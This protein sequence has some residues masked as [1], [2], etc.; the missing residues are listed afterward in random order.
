MSASTTSP[1][2]VSFNGNDSTSLY[3]EAVAGLTVTMPG[4]I[5][6]IAIEGGA[7]T[8]QVFNTGA[9]LAHS[10]DRTSS[11]PANFIFDSD[12][13]ITSA[14]ASGLDNATAHIEV[15]KG[16]NAV[17]KGVAIATSGGNTYLY[18]ANFRSGRVEVYDTNYK[19]VALTRL[20]TDFTLPSGY[21]PFNIQELGG[22]LYVT[23]AK[24]DDQ[25]HDD[26]AG[27]G[28]GFIDVFNNDGT[29]VGRLFS[30]GA[31]DSPWGLAIAPAGFGRFGRALLGSNFG[32]GR[33][34]A[35]DPVTGDAPG[36]SAANTTGRS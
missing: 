34:N 23:Y 35:Y 36:P 25:L 2:W 5:T 1:Q 19:P 31:L 18:A 10:F 27:L 8:G 13:G 6:N 4:N 7:P 32:N 12:T 28:H 16:A 9:F 11:K 26:V 30:R 21:A 24:Q 15:N 17:Y 3:T 22:K 14:W 33:I 29:L 20:I